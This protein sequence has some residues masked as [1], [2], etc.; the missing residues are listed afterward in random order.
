MVYIFTALGAVP[1][2]TN[3]LLGRKLKKESYKMNFRGE[4]FENY[5]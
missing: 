3:I 2:I 4:L 1:A 5:E